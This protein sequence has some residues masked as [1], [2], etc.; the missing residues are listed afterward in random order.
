MVDG[1]FIA[2]D[3]EKKRAF[4]LSHRTGKIKSPAIY[5]TSNDAIDFPELPGSEKFDRILCDVPCSGD[6]TFRK[7]IKLWRHFHCHMGH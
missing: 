4:V 2:N 3:I 5:V 7:N 6:G 1:M